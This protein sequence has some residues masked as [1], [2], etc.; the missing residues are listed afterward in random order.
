MGA[1]TTIDDETRR[2]ITEHYRTYTETYQQIWSQ[3]DT[4]HDRLNTTDIEGKSAYLQLSYINAVISI[5]T[6]VD[7]HEESLRKLMNDRN[8]ETALESV[9]YRRKKLD[10]IQQ[11]LDQN[12]VWRNLASMLENKDVSSAHETALDRLRL[13]GT[14]KTPFLFATLGY[15]EKMCIDGNEA[16]LMGMDRTPQT[17]DIDRYEQLCQEICSE[18]PAL[19][20]ELDP[21]HLHWV[22]FDWQR[23]PNTNKEP[24]DEQQQ[25]D[26]ITHH[27]AW[28]DAALRDTA[29][30]QRRMESIV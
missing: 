20:E 11:S 21:F 28:F 16:N 27:D 5:Q 9:N 29:A 1:I 8:L 19:S 2:Q 18:F 14:V 26:P 6:P 13:V 23:H 3:L 30:I 4:I 12:T 25:A 10:S 24:Q 17:D 7:R 22:I 15:T